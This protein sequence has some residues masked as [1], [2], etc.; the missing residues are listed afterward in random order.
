MYDG[1]RSQFSDK[2]LLWKRL[3]K[4]HETYLHRT[5]TFKLQVL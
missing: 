1:G 4:Y 2:S 5:A 3:E